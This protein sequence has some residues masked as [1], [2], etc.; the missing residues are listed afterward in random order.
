VPHAHEPAP[1]SGSG[2]SSSG[3][4]DA[5]PKRF[6]KY[7]LIRKLAV[8]GMAEL[9]LGLQRSMAG[10]EKLVVIKRVLPK[11]ARDEDFARMLLDEARI[12]ATLN[13]PNVAHIY[14]V[15]VFDG[16]YYIAMEHI[17]GEDLRSIVRQMRAE[18]VASFPLEHAL[19][20]VLGCC[21]GLAY[22]HDKRDL[23]GVPLNIVHRDVSPQNILVTFSGDVKLVDFGIAKA[24][25]SSMEDTK[26]GKLKG[27]V[28]YMSPEQAQGEP[29][30]AR[31]DVFSLGVILFELSTGRR[32]FKGTSE[33]DTMRMIAEGEYPRPRTIN[34]ALPERL[35]EIIVRALTRNREHRY[36]SARAFQ[37]DLE[38]FIRA[39]RL[40]VS[41]LSLG[42]WMQA[43]FAMKLQQQRQMLQ[44]GR[45]LAEVIAAQV[46]EEEA[47]AQHQTLGSGVRPRKASRLPWLLLG[48]VLV[49]GAVA[50]T[51]VPFLSSSEETANPADAGVVR[52][53]ST[54][55]GAA[56]WIDGDRRSDRTPATI[57][58]L[59][60]G[61]SYTIK[62]TSDGY[63]PFTQVVTLTRELT[64]TRLSARLE[65]P[66]AD[67]YAM[68]NIRTVPS[69][70]RVLLDGSET[71]KTTPTTI[72][73]IDPSVE[74]SL[75]L[76]FDGYETTTVPLTLGQGQVE[77]LAF[78]LERL[79]LGPDEAILRLRT[80]PERAR[81][82]LGGETYEDG[83]PHEFRGRA[84]RVRLEVESAGYHDDRRTLDLAGGEVTEL[85]IALRRRPS[86]P[87]GN[88]GTSSTAGDG[89][90]SGSPPPSGPGLLT[91]DARPWCNVSIDGAAAGQTPIVSRA[92]ASGSH[93]V[94]CT[95]PEL[96]VSQTVTVQID[97]G[98]HVRRR[99]TLQ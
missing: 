55:T 18:S 10:F 88:P 53:D 48:L 68:I 81:V 83:S 44:E 31:S 6:G 14:D 94:V 25:R 70:A 15:G 5:L 36:P 69:G 84:E 76:V 29:L 23:D 8:G 33:Y 28:P 66:S 13:H 79:P 54:P 41:P 71:G 21:A 26:S 74:H 32:L 90:G 39:E 3:A 57:R 2:P 92:L 16:Q 93:R 27:K 7:T 38:G 1:G 22:A 63:S 59:P 35:E 17:H 95:N 58:G 9:F 47:E 82:R 91:F 46:A 19:A 60:I 78:E 37:S 97:P 96:G 20:I 24:G 77:D 52:I 80:V 67:S 99:I 43:L 42:E 72:A 56:I 75:S 61:A 12:A 34:P 11:L 4:P 98:E 50:A 49:L 73:E 87:S 51:A 65:R 45:Q 85:E 89:P 64:E 30:D 86:S 62:L 40:A